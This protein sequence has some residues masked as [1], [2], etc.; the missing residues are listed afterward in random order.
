MAQRFIIK[1]NSNDKCYHLSIGKGI[2]I[3]RNYENNIV[4]EKE[5]G[6]ENQLSVDSDFWERYSKISNAPYHKIED[7]SFWCDYLK[8][9]PKNIGETSIK[10]EKTT[11][12]T[13]QI[14]SI[15]ISII[16]LFSPSIIDAY[17]NVYGKDITKNNTERAFFEKIIRPLID[18][19]NDELMRDVYNNFETRT[20]DEKGEKISYKDFVESRK[21]YPYFSG[22]ITK[23]VD[24]DFDCK[25]DAFIT[26]KTMCEAERGG[27]CM[28]FSYF[29]ILSSKDYEIIACPLE[30]RYS[31]LNFKNGIIISYDTEYTY[32]YKHFGYEDDDSSCYP[33]L[34]FTRKYKYNGNQ[35]E[36]IYEKFEGRDKKSFLQP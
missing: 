36:K 16:G 6:N 8:N 26:C 2:F 24:L 33:S 18:V 23:I 20:R 3:V 19:T 14:V 11:I 7:V 32:Y 29:T 27:G 28:T 4:F 17:N 5:K 34:K 15:I 25:N 21:E 1:E 22:E 31:E 9:A 35:F 12:K 10:E 30:G 13:S